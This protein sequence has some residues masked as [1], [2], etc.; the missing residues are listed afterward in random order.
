[1]LVGAG[2]T[3]RPAVLEWSKVRADRRML[4]ALTKRSR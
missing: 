4:S 1:M 2:A 3:V